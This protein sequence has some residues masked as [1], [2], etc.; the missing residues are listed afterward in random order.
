MAP[1]TLR[2]YIKSSFKSVLHIDYNSNI[3]YKQI[4]EELSNYLKNAG[5]AKKTKKEMKIN[6]LEQ[7]GKEELT[8]NDILTNED[9]KM[10]VRI[11]IRSL[12]REIKNKA[13][14]EDN[15][16]L[17]DAIVLFDICL[18]NTSSLS[19]IFSFYALNFPSIKFFVIP[20]LSTTLSSKLNFKSFSSILIFNK[21]EN[22]NIRELILTNLKPIEK[23]G[24]EKNI[25]K[26]PK[27]VTP[28]GKNFGKEKKKGQKKKKN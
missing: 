14:L 12:F 9:R 13:N 2:P 26:T 24:E 1:K 3:N 18:F 19:Q 27:L 23:A 17:Q 8:S 16:M 11:G 15:L 25:F 20:Q 21:E 28:I 10:L 5:F 7:K 22:K 6:S 4:L